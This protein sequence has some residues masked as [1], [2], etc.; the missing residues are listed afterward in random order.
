MKILTTDLYEGAWFLTQGMELEDLIPHPQK[1][2][3]VV[4]VFIGDRLEGLKEEYRRGIASGN[5]VK[6][7]QAIDGLKDRMFDLLRQR[8]LNEWRQRQG[9]QYAG[10]TRSTI[11]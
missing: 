8:E 1:K 6:Y 11:Q 3:S 4:F 10:A 9:G 5:V 7:R 2:K